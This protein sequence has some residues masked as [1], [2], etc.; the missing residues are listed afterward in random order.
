MLEILKINNVALIK[1]LELNLGKGFNV[2]LGE[3]GAGKSIII[4]ALNFVLGAKADRTLIRDNENFMKVSAK[5]NTKNIFIYELFERL[6][7][8]IQDGEIVLSRIYYQQGRNDARVNGEPVSINTLREIGDSLIDAYIQH[9]SVSLLKQK[10]HLKILDSY[11]SLELNDLKSKI[12]EK[13]IVLNKIVKEIKDFGGS[14]ENRARQIDLL[15]YQI[16]EIEDANLKENEDINLN[17]KLEKMS[18]SEKILSALNI[19]NNALNEEENSVSELIRVSLRT[20][21]GLEKYDEK[22]AQINTQLTEINLNLE[23]IKESVFDLGEEYNFDE[24]VLEQFILRREKID[25]LKRKYGTSIEKIYNFLENSKEELDKLENAEEM[26]LKKENEKNLALKE[27]SSLMDRLWAIRKKHASEIEE[28]IV[29]GLSDLGMLKAQFKINFFPLTDSIYSL[30]SWSIDCLYDIEFLFSAN[31]GEDLKPLVKTISG[32]E[33]NRFMLV[34]KN[35]IAETYGSE[36]LIF[37]EID[38]GI[39]GKIAN[40]VAFKIAKLSKQYQVLCITHLAQV[41]SMGDSFYFVS[42][43]QKENRTETHIKKLSDNE[44][45]EQIALLAYGE[46]N[47]NSLDF[48]KKMLLKNKQIK[49]NID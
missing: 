49:I 47:P 28:K 20:L 44:I 5:F 7:L 23:D 18:H 11:K 14:E 10:N 42:K 22:I 40:S 21:S 6:G 16:K 27:I 43:T 33:L 30:E 46:I 48:A 1:N 36:T 34:F 37:D 41:A 39:S 9:E 31:Y 38:S 4:D 19:V 32:G 3:T 35:I 12:E 25:A 26:L 2:I 8:T 29:E 24:Q 17:E 15:S 45:I 13:L